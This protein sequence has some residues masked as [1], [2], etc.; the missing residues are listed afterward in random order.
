MAAAKPRGYN[1]A[2]AY[3]IMVDYRVCSRC[4]RPIAPGRPVYW[5]RDQDRIPRPYHIECRG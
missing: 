5:L 4:W 1:L 2:E 3:E